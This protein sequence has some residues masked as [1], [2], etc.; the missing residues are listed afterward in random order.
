MPFAEERIW[1]LNHLPVITATVDA[2]NS[3]PRQGRGSGQDQAG[4]LVG[5][6][7]ARFL[8]FLRATGAPNLEIGVGSLLSSIV[9]GGLAPAP[10]LSGLMLCLGVAAVLRDFFLVPAHCRPGGLAE[11]PGPSF[12]T[13]PSRICCNFYNYEGL[14]CSSKALRNPEEQNG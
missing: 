7:L 6:A 4:L 1:R 10:E 13:L 5:G 8:Q 2:L 3:L 12:A 11:H 14:L 9:A